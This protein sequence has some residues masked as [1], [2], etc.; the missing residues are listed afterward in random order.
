MGQAYWERGGEI[1]VIMGDYSDKSIFDNLQKHGNPLFFVIA[2]KQR[3]HSVNC[4]CIPLTRFDGTLSYSV[5]FRCVYLVVHKGQ[6]EEAAPSPNELLVF[7]W[8]LLV[9][10]H[11]QVPVDSHRLIVLAQLSVV[12]F[13]T[14]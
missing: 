10:L 5:L 11:S 1:D 9:C 12:Q 14:D 8:H 7:V 4:T 2:L 13:K 6:R 3:S